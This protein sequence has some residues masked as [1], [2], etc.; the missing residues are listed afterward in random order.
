[1]S[2]SDSRKNTDGGAAIPVLSQPEP[3]NEAA[4][5]RTLSSQELRAHPVVRNY[6][7]F[8]LAALFSLVVCLADRG[9]EWWCL[10]PS[11]I[12]C[13]SVL[14]NWNHG[15]PLVLFSLAG[16]LGVAGSRSRWSY[17]VWSRFSSPTLMD[18]LLC[19]AVLAY[20]SGH[21]RLLS[22]MSHIF[23]PELRHAR[24]APPDPLRRR[25]PDLINGKEMALLGFALPT[26]VALA[27]MVW[28]FV[29]KSAIW[30]ELPLN[31]PLALWRTLQIA[32][33]SLAVMAATGIVAGYLRW[34]AATP[35]ESL[36][37]LQ[38][39]C[40][41][42]TRREQS[43]LNRWLTWARLRALRNKESL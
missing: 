15:P 23:P 13:L 19:I 8:C 28:E 17:A 2:Q 12:G 27:V 9:L 22:L 43:S 3:G 36:I 6:M 41:R 11:L 25:S 37:Y 31:I 42:Q 5:Q 18:L 1:V 16:L 4:S 38:D 29:M 32:W 33:A 30:G 14:T 24:G 34:I 10:V 35:E 21:Y 7:L 39:Q 20:V 40:W 26:W